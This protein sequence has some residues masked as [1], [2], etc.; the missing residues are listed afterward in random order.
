ML[1]AQVADMCHRYGIALMGPNSLGITNRI[2]RVSYWVGVKGPDDAPPSGAAAVLQSGA[3]MATIRE[4]ARER[5]LLFDQV[6]STG[7]E[8]RLGAADF[9]EYLLQRGGLRA[10]G[11]MLEGIREPDR[12]MALADQALEQGVAIVAL[13]VGRSNKGRAAVTGH[14]GSLTGSGEVADAVFERHGIISVR[15]MDQWLEDMLLLAQGARPSGGRTVVISVS[16]GGSALIADL[17]AELE[18]EL[19]DLSPEARARLAELSPVPV[20]NPL[21]A[22]AFHTV[23]N[24]GRYTQVTDIVASDPNADVLVGV[25]NVFDDIPF[26]LEQV[27]A[28][29]KAHRTS[30][31]TVAICSFISGPVRPQVLAA[32]RGAGL[33]PLKGA[34][35]CLV[36]VKHVCAWN[37]RR[38]L[39]GAPRVRLVAREPMPDALSLP[40]DAARLDETTSKRVLRAFNF[41]VPPGAEVLSVE[42]ALRFAETI[43]FPVV[44]KLQ[45]EALPHKSDVGAVKV[46]L[47]T[48]EAVTAAFDKLRVIAER[49]G[50]RGARV[51]VERQVPAGHELI[52]GVKRDDVFGPVVVLGFGGIHV[53]VLSDVVTL[54]PPVTADEVYQMIG[55]LRG[56]ALL[57]GARGQPE[58]DLAALAQV[59][60]KTGDLALRLG[61]RLAGL[62]INPLIVLPA[63]QGVW[64]ADALLELAPVVPERQ[65][66]TGR[67]TEREADSR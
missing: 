48:P 59:I 32:A 14:T 45:H 54:P 37:A 66:V 6:V 60:V 29:G 30:G 28:L 41:P 9:L 24:P 55:R 62:D 7:N 27:E 65:L 56:A 25:L 23:E 63:G 49:G 21:D 2:D 13:K 53:A 31:K 10:V 12:L 36:A 26:Y 34:Q 20:E 39:A 35:K 43:G 51:L 61:P 50:L 11:L 5:G 47:D 38:R 18:I 15:D 17:A 57:K 67:E 22:G 42:E 64:V 19:S 3:M 44:M 8:A 1:Q 40:A 52:L 58:A 33:Y 46:G 16:G 4:C